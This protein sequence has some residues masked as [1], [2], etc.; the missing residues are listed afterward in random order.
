MISFDI[1]SLLTSIPLDKTIEIILQRIYNRNEMTMQIPKKIMKGLLL[2]CTTEVHFAYSNRIYQQNDGV[3]IEQRLGP[4]LAGLYM[5]EAETSIIATLGR[6]LLK[7]KRYVDDTFCCV[8]IGTV[9][10]ILNKL[11]GFHQNI[12]FTYKLEKNDKLAFLDV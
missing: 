11:N 10:D 5:L 1:K 4:V 12:Q 3:A 9:N 2:L 8:K 6:P 7:W